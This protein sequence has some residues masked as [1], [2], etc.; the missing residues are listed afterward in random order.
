MNSE[1]LSKHLWNF[2]WDGASISVREAK[3][4]KKF[5]QDLSWKKG[6]SGVRAGSTPRVARL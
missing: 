1:Q 2:N 4:M 3:K 6:D 5:S